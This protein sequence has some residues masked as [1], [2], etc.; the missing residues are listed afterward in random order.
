MKILILL[1]M[2]I[3]K[4]NGALNKDDVSPQDIFDKHKQIENG[5]KARARNSK[6]LYSRL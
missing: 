6:I 1:L 2:I 3:I 4:L 5:S